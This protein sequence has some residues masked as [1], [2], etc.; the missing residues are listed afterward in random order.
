MILV[1]AGMVIAAG[2]FRGGRLVRDDLPPDSRLLVVAP[3]DGEQERR[4]VLEGA[5][6]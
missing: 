5:S 3:P 6:G 1:G 4:Q 2:T